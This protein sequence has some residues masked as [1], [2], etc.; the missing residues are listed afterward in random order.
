MELLT[1]QE[2]AWAENRNS[3]KAAYI[4]LWPLELSWVIEENMIVVDNREAKCVFLS[5]AQ[6][7]GWTTHLKCCPLYQVPT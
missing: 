5:T 7:L 6:I 3:F 4:T 1:P 2:V